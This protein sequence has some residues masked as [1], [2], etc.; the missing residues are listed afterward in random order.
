MKA[1]EYAQRIID[2]NYS[3]QSISKVVFDMHKEIGVIATARNCQ[4]ASAL[5]SVFEEMDQRYRAMCKIIN[6]DKIRLN[7]KGF[8][9]YLQNLYAAMPLPVEI[10]YLK[11]SEVIIGV[12]MASG[13]DISSVHRGALDEQ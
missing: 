6:A 3:T 13:P 7:D 10:E 12:D 1:K 11:Q 9:L 8:K 2:D 4:S 5:N